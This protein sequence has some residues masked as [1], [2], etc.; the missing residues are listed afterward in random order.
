MPLLLLLC[1]S[2][3]KQIFLM[4][5]AAVKCLGRDVSPSSSKNKIGNNPKN[6]KV[7]VGTGASEN[8]GNVLEEL[9]KHN[10]FLKDLTDPPIAVVVVDLSLLM[11][12]Q[13]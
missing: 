3:W 12:Q 9:I 11:V 13:F 1:A 2:T 10:R 8:H 4:R 6:N 7:I 5:N